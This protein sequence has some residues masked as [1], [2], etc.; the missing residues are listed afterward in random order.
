MKGREAKTLEILRTW[1]AAVLRTYEVW[2][3]D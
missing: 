3:R 2:A 1:G